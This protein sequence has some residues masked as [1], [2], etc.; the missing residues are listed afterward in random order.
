MA[1]GARVLDPA[2]F[3]ELKTAL[4]VY[5]SA[6]EEDLGAIQREIE[7]AKNW[8]EQRVTHWRGQVNRLAHELSQAQAALARCQSEARSS[9]EQRHSASDCSELQRAVAHAKRALEQAQANLEIAKTWQMQ[10]IG[11]SEEFRVKAQG[12]RQNVS[13]QV[14]SAAQILSKAEADLEKYSGS[15]PISAG[16]SSS[17][18]GDNSSAP[19]EIEPNQEVK[20]G[21]LEP[22][23]LYKRGNYYF[24]TDDQK[25][26]S[27]VY[28]QLEYLPEEL[29]HRNVQQQRDAALLGIKDDDEGGHLIGARFNGSS[30][31]FNLIP[32]NYNLNRGDWKSMENS[33]E[34][35]IKN[36][37]DVIAQIEVL[38][39]SNNSS[40]PSLLVAKYDFVHKE[41]DERISNRLF[42]PN[43]SKKE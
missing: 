38:Y 20:I 3:G 5:Q 25:R 11:I 9:S 15:A 2:V 1:K 8:I 27:S 24:R 19:Q 16:A 23:T 33:W 30:D 6:T 32:Q 41:T 12:F 4:S 18:S 43:Q 17:K 21:D 13:N 14:A 37:Y 35:A 10:I 42:F 31:A 28:G 7:Q 29:R 39:P 26:I 40:R 36:G 22:N 34:T